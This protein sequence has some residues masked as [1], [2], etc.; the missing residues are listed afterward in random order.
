MHSRPYVTRSL[1]GKE[2]QV[3]NNFEVSN[4]KLKL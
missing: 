3:N 4:P 1:K 2:T